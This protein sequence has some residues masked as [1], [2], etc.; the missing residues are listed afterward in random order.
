M[1]KLLAIIAAAAIAASMTACRGGE[2]RQANADVTEAAT[3]SETEPAAETKTEA[4][5]ETESGSHEF[6][7]DGNP[8]TYTGGWS[9]DMPN[10][11]GTLTLNDGSIYSGEWENGKINGQ[12]KHKLA[13]GDV[14]E[15]EWK[16]NKYNG[17]GTYTS[18]SGVVYV[19]EFKDGYYNNQGKMTWTDGSFYEGE[20]KDGQRNG[21]GTFTAADGSVQSG[22]WKD[23]IFYG[24]HLPEGEFRTPENIVIV[25]ESD[26]EVKKVHVTW[27]H[28]PDALK[29][30]FKI[31]LYSDL[32]ESQA[33]QEVNGTNGASFNKIIDDYTYYLTLRAVGEKDG[34]AIYSD[35]I[36]IIFK[37]SAAGQIEYYSGGF[38][39]GKKNGQGKLTRDNGNVY[40]GEFKDGNYNGQ[41]KLTYADGGVYEGDFKDGT[42]NGQGKL[43]YANGTV[44]EGEFKDGHFVG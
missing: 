12:G 31:Y 23:G 19:G 28:V 8:G 4:E 29:Y 40:E 15:G 2:A 10:G 35:W 6:T 16:E 38:K 3:V 34:Q 18:A 21:Q 39:D 13:N 9:G 37:R 44:Y 1:K 25:D 24:D 43:T 5:Q 41:G 11:E 27:D 17:Q 26:N 14:Y 42:F 7:F 30:E 20:F 36:Y 22:L 33:S 32:K